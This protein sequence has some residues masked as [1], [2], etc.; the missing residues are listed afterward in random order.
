MTDDQEIKLVGE[1]ERGARAR[2]ILEDSFVQEA[3]HAVESGILDAWKKSPVRDTEGQLNLR[4]L[5]K[6]LH[7]FRSYFADAMTTGK[8]AEVQLNHERGL[9]E[10]ARAAVREFRR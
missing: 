1:S 6:C 2:R 7:D 5:Y 4:L 9:R 10:R 8:M 3:L